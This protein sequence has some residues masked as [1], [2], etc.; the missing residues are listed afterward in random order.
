[1]IKLCE[2]FWIIF[3]SVVAKT[4]LFALKK[5]KKNRFTVH[6]GEQNLLFTWENIFATEFKKDPMSQREETT[7]KLGGCSI[8]YSFYFSDSKHGDSSELNNWYA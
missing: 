2:G 3:V 4:H 8:L 7:H 6:C 5:K 1:M